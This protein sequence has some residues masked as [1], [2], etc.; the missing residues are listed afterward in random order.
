MQNI[1]CGQFNG[2]SICQN[3]EPITHHKQLEVIINKEVENP[4]A[5]LNGVR[6]WVLQVKKHFLLSQ[7]KYIFNLHGKT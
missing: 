5:R 6:L 4:Y 7:H 2:R 3:L 1:L